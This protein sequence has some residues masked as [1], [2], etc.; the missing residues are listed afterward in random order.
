MTLLISNGE[1]ATEVG[2]AHKNDDD[3]YGFD[4]ANELD[5]AESIVDSAW[6][7]IDGV[8]IQDGGYNGTV[9]KVW[10]DDPGDAETVE[11]INTI[12][13]TE[14]MPNGNPR[15]LNRTLSV[16]IRPL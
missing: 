7:A 6:S 16:P 1:S 3:S 14:L 4:W 8:S 5:E 12:Q 9:T 15:T 10:L 13:T 2:A 11:L